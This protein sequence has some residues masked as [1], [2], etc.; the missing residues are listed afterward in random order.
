MRYSLRLVFLVAMLLSPPFGALAQMDCQCVLEGYI[1]DAED[2]QPLVG[3]VLQLMEIDKGTVSD[4]QGYYRFAGICQG[5]YTLTIRYIGYSTQNQQL[6]LKAGQ[7]HSLAPIFLIAAHTHL[8]EVAISDNKYETSAVHHEQALE[9]KMLDRHTG[10]PLASALRELTGVNTLQTGPTIAKPVIHGL[11][12]NRVLVMNNGIRQEGQQW[13]TEHAPDIDPFV[14]SRIAV[15][16]GAEAVRYGADAV[17]GVVLLRPPHLGQSEHIHG[18][19]YTVGMTNGRGGSGSAMLEGRIGKI[20]GSG[21]RVQGTYKK[22]GDAQAANYLLNNTGVEELNFSAALG[23]HKARWGVEL[24]ASRFDTRLGILSA[25]HIGNVVDMQAA[26]ERAV[27]QR[28]QPFSYTISN[29]FQQVQHQLYKLETYYNLPQLGKLELV[30]G[31]QKNLREEYDIRRGGRS[32]RPAIAMD[33]GT[34]SLD[35]SLQHLPWLNKKLEGSI[36]ISGWFQ[37]NF[38]D[39]QLTGS[40]RLIPDYTAWNLGVYWIE[41]IGNEHVQFEW[42]A[43]YDYRRMEVFVFEDRN[44][45]RRDYPTFGNVSASVGLWKSLP[46]DWYSKIHL[47]LAWRPPNIN[48]LYSE[49]LHHGAAAIELGDQNLNPEQ[50]YKLIA[51]LGKQHQRWTLELSPFYQHIQNYIY[52]LPTGTQ[53]TIRGAFPVFS[54]RQNDVHFYGLDLDAQYRLTQRWSVIGKASVLEAQA[55]DQSNLMWIPPSRYHLSLQYNQKRSWWIVEDF[56]ASLEGVFVDQQ[57]NSPPVLQDWERFPEQGT[58]DFRGAPPAYFLLQAQVG[59][60]HPLRGEQHRIG[61]SLAV[62]NALNQA[63]RDYMNRLRYF[64]DDLGRNVI[65]RLKYSF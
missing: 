2:H 37:D 64:A 36:G 9:A 63:Y 6:T 61:V 11:H 10:K 12:S 60:E 14:A 5:T 43:R 65:L 4:A 58:F 35:L 34:H 57:R 8:A 26:I 45:L 40:N 17:G 16:K 38:N 27:P 50:A 51:T 29:P 33:L 59:W 48:E 18:H 54:Y 30:Y 44:T 46:N 52:L 39:I 22:L 53:T 31:Y 7:T 19:L 49:G 13:G 23:I 42:G 41:R 25:A 32:E 1:R 62:E 21:W 55:L 56:F 47:G 15:V 24:Y 20:Q 3:A 28:L